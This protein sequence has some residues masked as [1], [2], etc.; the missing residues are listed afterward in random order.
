MGRLTVGP[1]RP[2]L[3][4]RTAS[5]SWSR[6][7]RFADSDQGQVILATDTSIAAKCQL[8][9][10]LA[11]RAASATTGRPILLEFWERRQVGQVSQPEVFQEGGGRGKQAVIVEE[12]T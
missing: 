7:E 3:S 9:Y 5:R 11:I 4:S 1:K 12:C 8:K 6:C 2:P 10:S